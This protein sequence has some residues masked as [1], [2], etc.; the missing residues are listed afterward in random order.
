MS[1][2]FDRF[3]TNPLA[4]VGEGLRRISNLGMKYDDMVIKQSR[5]IGPTEATLGGEFA[6]RDIAYAFALA[7]VSQKKYT[8]IFDKDYVSRRAFLQKFALNSEI[9]FMVTTLA[10]EAIVYDD[11]NYFAYP[12]VSNLDV[13]ETIK[14][15]LSNEFK[16]IYN[17]FGFVDDITAWHYFR[18][19][20]IDGILAFEI[21]Y[22]P[23][24]ENIIGF[25]ELDG[26][27]MKPDIKNENGVFKKVWYLYPDRP[28]MTR[29]LYD[30]QVIFL[31]YAKGNLPSRISYVEN[32][33]RSFNLL[34][35]IENAMVMWMLMNATWRVKM[36]VP[37][38]SKSPQKA[39]ESLA[40]LM[41]IYKEDIILDAQDGTL[42]INGSPSV[43]QFYKNYLFPSK[44]GE[45]VDISTM[46]GEGPDLQNNSLLMYWGN[47]LKE[48][49]KIPFSRF[50]KAQSGGQLTGSAATGVDRE[51][52]R[53]YKF[54]NRIRSAFQELL[55][56]P[57]WIQMCL[58][59]KELEDDEIFRSSMGL[60]FVKDN[61]FEEI[62]KQEV[63][64]KRLE[65]VQSM[66][67]LQDENG[68]AFFSTKWLVE[69][70]LRLDKD[71]LEANEAAKL[72][73]S[74]AQP[75]EGEEG[76]GEGGMPPDTDSSPDT[77]TPPEESSSDDPGGN[78]GL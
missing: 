75:V 70:Y 15:A 39:K 10:D 74:K 14:D 35:I 33:V 13:S 34:R 6:P 68:K 17:Y 51:E 45:Q 61:L 67:A 8:P 56:K 42:N 59:F 37:I 7:D 20:L 36:V 73:Y 28:N 40:E 16:K 21:V 57:L 54:T 65:F 18:Q 72:A 60:R 9:D 77:D 32:L 12:S 41:A 19:F 63:L 78:L 27:F 69:N 31:S 22:D 24:G 48:D 47:K 3:G 1:G 53:F 62:R 29:T 44:N 30:T 46:G 11:T 71:E 58:K 23:K 49:S 2:F 43:G 76:A 52:I 50:D 64:T 66:Q 5:A 26:A 25:K 4:T 55:I 38:G